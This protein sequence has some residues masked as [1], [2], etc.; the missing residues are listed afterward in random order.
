MAWP[1]IQNYY[2]EPE[3][4]VKPTKF[5]RDRCKTP[6]LGLKQAVWLQDK[7]LCSQESIYYIGLHE[8]PVPI[9]RAVWG[10]CHSSGSMA[11]NCLL[12]LKK[13]GDDIEWSLCVQ[14]MC[15]A[16]CP[17][18]RAC[19]VPWGSPPPWGLVLTSMPRAQDC[20]T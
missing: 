14:S 20:C 3:Q 15:R 19:L 16:R 6:H 11:K 2:N 17:F 1:G 5:K 13:R 8:S 18:I 9:P 7:A 12:T 4:R 10:K